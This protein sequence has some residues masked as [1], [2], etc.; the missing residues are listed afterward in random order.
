M[1]DGD[2]VDV[3]SIYD[4]KLIVT[5]IPRQP[6]FASARVWVPVILHSCLLC[7]KQK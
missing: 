4:Y 3:G 1:T 5:N 7:T 2:N 6:G